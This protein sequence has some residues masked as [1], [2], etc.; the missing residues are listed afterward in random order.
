[1][2]KTNQVIENENAVQSK[3]EI[4]EVDKPKK[5]R[6]KKYW[7]LYIAGFAFLV[8]ASFTIVNQS[9]EV[10]SRREVL[11]QL[12]DELK[13]VEIKSENLKKVK[14][15]KGKDLSDYIE[16]IAREDLDFVKNGERIFIIESGD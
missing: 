11:K 1:M 13:I 12:N 14:N 3:E 8:Y 7:P 2:K 9:I 10:N 5:K 6:N 4:R 15:Y 16:S